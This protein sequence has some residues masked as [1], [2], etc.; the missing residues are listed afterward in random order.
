MGIHHPSISVLW[1]T[2]RVYIT[3][4]FL[5]CPFVNCRGLEGWLYSQTF[6]LL[7]VIIIGIIISSFG[8]EYLNLI[9]KRNLIILRGIARNFKNSA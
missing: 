4:D 5:I 9:Y 3:I 2:N 1:L 7:S 8:F 6:L